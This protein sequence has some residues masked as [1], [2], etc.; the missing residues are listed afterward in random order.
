MT[1]FRK[2]GLSLSVAVALG[3]SAI[4]SAQTVGYNIRTGDVWVDN[5][6]GEINDYGR[7][8]RDPFIGEMTSNY[9]VPRSFVT[10]LLDQRRWS[11]GDV[12]Y[13]CAI[14]SVLKLPCR[15]V[16]REY[17]RNPG[18]GWGGVA[19]RMG[20]KPGSPQFHALKRG[21]VN[22]YDR[23]GH[24]ISVDRDVRVDWSQHGPGKG[25]V[26]GKAGKGKSATAHHAGMDHG[27]GQHPK[28]QGQDKG[29]G[30]AKGNSGKADAGNK[31]KGNAKGNG[32]GSGKPQ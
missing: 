18:Q 31:D 5:R 30:A 19:K 10:E 17:D 9:G 13:A 26:V 22:T 28:G 4:A 27:P 7:Q 16:V 12:Y 14:A 6:M 29:K 23:W 21:T 32:K 24:P 2:F 25:K 8:Y 15:D 11:P 3:A 1:T 20:I